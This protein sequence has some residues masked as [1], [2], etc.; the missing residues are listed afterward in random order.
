[1]KLISNLSVALV[2]LSI[3]EGA[4]GSFSNDGNHKSNRQRGLKGGKASKKSK[5][6]KGGKKPR[7]VGAVYTMSNAPENKLLAFSQDIRSGALAFEVAVS[8]NGSGAILANTSQGDPLGSQDAI[9]V[10]K[11]CILSVNAGSNAIASFSIGSDGF[12]PTFV[13]TYPS[14]GVLP[15]SLTEYKGLVYVLNAG[16]DGSISGYKL[17]HKKCI[18]RPIPGSTVTLKQSTGLG[19]EDPPAAASSPAQVGFTPKG[20]L[21][22]MI[23]SQDG[24]FPPEKGKGS[25]NEYFVD[26]KT[27]LV[28]IESTQTFVTDGT[29][30]FSFEFDNEGNLLLTEGGEKDDPLTSDGGALTSYGNIDINAK[31]LERVQTDGFATC[32]VRYAEKTGCTFTANN[33]G[34]ISSLR[35]KKG[36]VI[37]LLN[38]SAASLDAPT[39][40]DFSRDEKYLYALST[41]AGDGPDDQ[42]RIYA[43]K[44]NKK[45]VITE[46]QVISDGLPDIPTSLNGV[47]GLATC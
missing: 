18:L 31:F 46:V 15:V 41:G 37:E 47:A 33:G 5:N 45:C 44:V 29:V 35:V 38:S 32:W 26:Q 39:D 10:V 3:C 20:N 2:A 7:N 25:I 1:M 40:M 27:G 16:V 22:V 43:Y 23:K 21:I 19:P 6:N 30:P 24:I 9:I 14:N 13:D 8:T 17:N 36:G 42:P 12:T 4:F 34:T 11:G 28:G